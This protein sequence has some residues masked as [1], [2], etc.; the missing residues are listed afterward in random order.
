MNYDKIKVKVLEV[1]KYCKVFSFPI[2]CFAI[3]DRLH[4]K[5]HSYS[6]M[7]EKKKIQCLKISDEAF[8]L[9]NEIYYNDR[10]IN[11]RV[12]FSLMHELGHILFRHGLNRTDEEEKE[13]NFFAKYIL[14]PPMVIHCLKCNTTKHLSIT[15]DVTNEF[16]KYCLNYYNTWLKY[17]TD[18]KLPMIEREIYKHFYKGNIYKI[19]KRKPILLPTATTISYRNRYYDNYSDMNFVVAESQWLY[20]GI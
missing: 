6:S 16:S 5:Y 20:G 11:G 3:L 19:E 13:A 2:D 1:Y 9:K 10:N 15:F 14:A 18:Y 4:I 17:A 12:R 7:S 8:V